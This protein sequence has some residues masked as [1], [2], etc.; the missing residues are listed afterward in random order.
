MYIAQVTEVIVTGLCCHQPERK[1][2][3]I[4]LTVLSAL[5]LLIDGYIGDSYDLAAAI[6]LVKLSF[7]FT[8]LG[9]PKTRIHRYHT[10]RQVISRI[11]RHADLQR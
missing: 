3:R 9:S 8:D 1:K 7:T 5:P 2:T 4:Q 6:I 11:L 10:N